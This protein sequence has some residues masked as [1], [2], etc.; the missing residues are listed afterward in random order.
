MTQDSVKFCPQCGSASVEFSSL[1]MGQGSCK[2]CGWQ[3]L[4]DD[5]LTVPIQ[6]DFVGREDVLVAMVNDVRTF[7]S[8]ELG[9]PWLKFLLKWGF[10]SG[11]LNNAAATIDRK[12]FARYLAI[13]GQSAVTALIAQ[14]VRDSHQ[15]EGQASGNK[16]S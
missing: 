15:A 3:G 5:L 10:I 16:P 14:R 11:D 1:A 7:L 6:H 4:A 2:G 9:L 12:K 8:G 13:I